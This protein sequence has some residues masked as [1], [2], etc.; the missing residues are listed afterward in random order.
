MGT[1]TSNMKNAVY[2]ETPVIQQPGEKDFL[3]FKNSKINVGIINLANV[4]NYKSDNKLV[5]LS[6]NFPN[7]EEVDI[8]YMDK[9]K[10]IKKKRTKLDVEK[11]SVD[12]IYKSIIAITFNDNDRSLTNNIGCNWF[13]KSVDSKGNVSIKS[14]SAAYTGGNVKGMT[15]KF[16]GNTYI[17][18]TNGADLTKK[19]FTISAWINLNGNDWPKSGHGTIVGCKNED[20]TDQNLH[21]TLIGGHPGLMRLGFWGDDVD[22]KVPFTSKDKKW[23]HV[24]WVHNTTTK[25]SKLYVNNKLVGG[26]KHKGQYL[27]GINRIGIFGDH[28]STIFK[29]LMKDV[30][31]FDRQLSEEEIDALYNAKYFNLFKANISS[32]NLPSKP[33]F[34]AKPFEAE[35]ILNTS[36]DNDIVNTEIAPIDI[37]DFKDN[38]L[39][40]TSPIGQGKVFIN[41]QEVEIKKPSIVKLGNLEADP[42]KDGKCLINMPLTGN[43]LNIGNSNVLIDADSVFSNIIDN[44]SVKGNCLTFKT[45]NNIILAQTPNK[46]PVTFSITSWFKIDELSSNIVLFGNDFYGVPKASNGFDWWIRYSN[47]YGLYIHAGRD[48]F[49]EFNYSGWTGLKEKEWYFGYFEYAPNALRMIIHNLNGEKVY[50]KTFKTP[51][52]LKQTWNNYIGIGG[53]YSNNGN[54]KWASFNGSLKQFKLFTRS[55]NEAEI[56]YLLNEN[57][58]TTF[59]TEVENLQLDES[60]KLAYKVKPKALKPLTSG[61]DDFTVKTDLV[62]DG[63]VFHG[64]INEDLTDRITGK[65]VY[66]TN[67]PIVSKLDNG[68]IGFNFSNTSQDYMTLPKEV[69]VNLNSKFT[70]SFNLYIPDI[71]K[72]GNEETLYNAGNQ[73]SELAINNGFLQ[74]AAGADWT[75]INIKKLESK[76]LYNITVTNDLIKSEYTVFINGDKAFKLN[77][78]AGRL[79][80]SYKHNNVFSFMSRI[81]YT[82]TFYS[83]INAQMFNARVY[84]RLLTESEITE[85]SNEFKKFDTKVDNFYINK[86]VSKVNNI[87]TG[88]ENM[89]P[90]KMNINV[91]ENKFKAFN[92]KEVARVYV[93]KNGKITAEGNV[94]I[95]QFKGKI[96]DDYRMGKVMLFEKANKH[97]LQL[98]DSPFGLGPIKRNIAVAGWVHMEPKEDS[99]VLINDGGGENGY[100]IGIYQNKFYLDYRNSDKNGNMSDNAVNPLEFETPKTCKWY[101]IVVNYRIEGSLLITEIFVNGV[102]V[103]YRDTFVNKYFVGDRSNYV[104]I[105]GIPYNNQFNGRNGKEFY[106]SIRVKEV[107]FFDN[108][109]LTE[110]DIE[111][112]MSKA[113]TEFNFNLDKEISNISIPNNISVLPAENIDIN[114][115][116]QFGDIIKQSRAVQRGIIFDKDMNINPPFTS[117]IFKLK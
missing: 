84:N 106:T 73:I 99:A 61:K 62:T 115:G 78:N 104:Y 20:A 17:K 44:D 29:G 72:V 23:R 54:H 107:M 82:S 47:A 81:D 3:E 55:L 112:L 25:E 27:S 12:F 43:L 48:D 93:D 10:K 85:L 98:T 21:F 24:V 67:K 109:N 19:D 71:N 66:C 92:Q 87:I 68:L 13:Y 100:G 30:A 50:D 95:K 35:M 8:I 111:L 5:N 22:V 76:K 91:I 53:G 1:I 65:P 90:E 11:V 41:G 31:I 79:I 28:P 105:G 7:G 38:K 117:D 18:L 83:L 9:D 4:S 74:I 39:I 60:I 40:S 75:W 16:D 77:R 57:V 6:Y 64:L 86:P 49:G 113:K 108:T 63:L 37:V 56:K 32:L 88:M 110:S 114:G 59:E 102:R 89:I 14:R 116:V 52:T 26:G 80:N 94:G 46:I 101:H 97:F 96:I 2:L 34:I 33:L 36:M 45:R 15:A 103:D 42:F 51:K 69:T 70:I 58:E